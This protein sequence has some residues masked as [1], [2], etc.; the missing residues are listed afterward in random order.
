MSNQK[1]KIQFDVTEETE[2][3]LKRL[4]GKTTL[5]SQDYRNIIQRLIDKVF[6]QTNGSKL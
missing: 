5:Q 2:F 4:C 1:K 3:K 6:L